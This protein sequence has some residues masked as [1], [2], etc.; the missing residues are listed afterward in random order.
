MTKKNG[1][2]IDSVY[3]KGGLAEEAR[4]NGFKPCHDELNAQRHQQQAH[5]T[6]NDVNAGLSKQP[7]QPRRHT[8]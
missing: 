6:G 7:H 3:M 5:D 2:N 1:A 4:E 8:E